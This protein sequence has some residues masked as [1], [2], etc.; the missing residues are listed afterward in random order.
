MELI[1]RKGR[2]FSHSDKAREKVSLLQSVVLLKKS[3][4]FVSNPFCQ[5]FSLFCKI[6]LVL[7]MLAMWPS[8][9]RYGDLLK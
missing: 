9:V 3:F 1:S 4:V 5:L 7:L 2:V 6:C 8:S